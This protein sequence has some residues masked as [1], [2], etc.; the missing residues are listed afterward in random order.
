MR[1]RH[2]FSLGSPLIPSWVFGLLLF[3]GTLSTAAAVWAQ[4]QTNLIPYPQLQLVDDNQVNL[5]TGAPNISDPTLSIGQPGKGGL[6]YTKRWDNLTSALSVLGGDGGWL[7]SLW[8]N[9][10]LNSSGAS[11]F[12][13]G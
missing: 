6:T 13:D 1:H 3:L 10:T 5:A 2:G 11:V 9:V 7:A 4:T 8:G 12:V